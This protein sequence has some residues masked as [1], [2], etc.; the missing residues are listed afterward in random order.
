MTTNHTYS[1]YDFLS[2]C[3]GKLAKR[4]FR[5]LLSVQASVQKYQSRLPSDSLL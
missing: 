4:H 5:L 2:S 1:M 3:G